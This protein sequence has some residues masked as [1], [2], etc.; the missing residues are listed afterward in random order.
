LLGLLI[1]EREN[2]KVRKAKSA[3]RIPEEK[4]KR[5]EVLVLVVMVI[6]MENRQRILGDMF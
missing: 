2:K 6:V 3:T 4:K 1:A 5:E